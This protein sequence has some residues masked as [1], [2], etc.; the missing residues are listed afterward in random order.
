MHRSVITIAALAGLILPATA[1]P[2]DILG[3]WTRGDG[4]ARVKMAACGSDICA[5]N[6]WIKDPVE[7]KE[8]VGDKL[9]FKI[10]QKGDGWEGTGYDP[11]RKLNL[12]A[13]LK[14]TGNAMTT[15]GCVVAG[16][17]CRSTQWTRAN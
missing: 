6:I 12:T 5:T 15:T 3:T 9:I 10:A 17:I 8:K 7:Q 14:A 16:M 1:A 2:D 11:Q 13:T 4:L